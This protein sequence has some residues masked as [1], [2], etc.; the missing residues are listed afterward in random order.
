M[1]AVAEGLP[2]EE[3]VAGF[4]GGMG[5]AEVVGVGVGETVDVSVAVKEVA[6]TVETALRVAVGVLSTGGGAT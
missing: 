6:V 2:L 1:D 3:A 4:V 5:G